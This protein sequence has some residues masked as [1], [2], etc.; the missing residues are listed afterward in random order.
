[1]PNE[2]YNSLK[3]IGNKETID[4][5]VK[6]NFS[7]SYFFPPPENATQEWFTNNW[8]ADREAGYIEL[9]RTNDDTLYIR[10]K[11]AWTVP[12]EFLKNL[13]RK[14]PELYIFNQYCI[15]FTDCGIVIL[16]M[17]KGELNEKEFKW[18][19]PIGQDYVK[20]VYDGSGWC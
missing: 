3:L 5:I 13:I 4:E 18:F 16:Y 9:D 10:C 14:F 17:Y 6:S 11:T 12:I 15:E 8:C 20:G 1:M 2:C 7:F 19:D